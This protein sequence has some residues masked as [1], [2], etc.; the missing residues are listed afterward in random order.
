MLERSASLL[1]TGSSLTVF[2]GYRFVKR[3]FQDA[4][5]VAIVN[6]GPTRGDTVATVRVEGRLG[7]VLPDLV[8]RLESA[9][10]P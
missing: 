4:K 10:R 3:A 2:S 8:D 9:T 5:P 7:K 6:V 1:V